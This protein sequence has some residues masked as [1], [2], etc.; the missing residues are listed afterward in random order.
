M[1]MKLQQEMLEEEAMFAGIMEK[2]IQRIV[3]LLMFLM[4][5][6]LMMNREGQFILLHGQEEQK[7]SLLMQLKR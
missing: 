3:G 6:V 5:L 4:L 7:S 2:Q 1:E